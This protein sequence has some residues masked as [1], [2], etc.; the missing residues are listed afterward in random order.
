MQSSDPNPQ[1]APENSQDAGP[2]A[3]AEEKSLT[4]ESAEATTP[5]DMMSG[6]IAKY[7]EER[8]QMKDQ[9]LRAVAEAEN[10]RRRAQRDQEETSKY[11]ITGFA[12]D[13]VSV[14]ENLQRASE[15]IPADA[16]AGSEMLKTL[17]E[18]VDMT[19]RELLSIFERN[20]IQRVYP[21]GEKFDHNYHQAV[22]QI[23]NPTVA[24]GTVV[25]VLQAGYKIHDRLLRPAMVA[26]SKQPSEEHKV[27]TKA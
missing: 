27:D 26:V 16:R 7:E 8:A 2:S 14:I 4:P 24:A 9:L 18:G 17:G 5:E 11:A 23:E 12:R 3:Q 13:L 22:V 19:M 20:G 15:S 21:M 10:T 1:G 6:L 25:Q